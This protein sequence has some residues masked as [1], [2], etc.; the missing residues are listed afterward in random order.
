MALVICP[1]GCRCHPGGMRNSDSECQPPT[2]KM[3]PDLPDEI[4]FW[5]PL[6]EPKLPVSMM[7][8]CKECGKHFD[9]VVTTKGSKEYWCPACGEVQTFDLEDFVNRAVEQCGKMLGKPSRG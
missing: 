6:S 2:L 9:I 5:K 1:G 7:I 3:R 4:R 8:Y